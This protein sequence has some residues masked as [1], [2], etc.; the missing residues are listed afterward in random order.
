MK[1]LFLSLCLVMAAMSLQ[2]QSKAEQLKQIRQVYAQA[3][4][5]AGS[6]KTEPTVPI[7]FTLS[8]TERTAPDAEYPVEA[9][10]N[11]RFFFEQQGETGE[12]RVCTLITY[13]WEA[14]GHVTYREF[15]FDPQKGHLL[16]S[17]MK[18]ETHAGFK[19]ETRYYYDGAGNL[20]EQK[21]KINDQEASADAHSWS[22]AEGDREMAVKY[23][24][25]AD[26][27]M[28]NM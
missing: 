5:K 20:I 18:A 7:D 13:N 28:C 21:H 1:Q 23:L 9:N 12:R 8:Y 15:L 4:E 24:Q 17:F 6:N 25:M 26:A 14:D 2:A 19:V 22:S 10:T 16:F 3:K 27:V 11:I